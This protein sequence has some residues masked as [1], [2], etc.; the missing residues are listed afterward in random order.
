MKLLTTCIIK[1]GMKEVVLQ[2]NF[3]SQYRGGCR[4]PKKCW[5]FFHAWCAAQTKLGK[6]P[7]YAY[8][9]I[10]LACSGLGIH[11]MFDIEVPASTKAT[12]IYK[13]KQEILNRGNIVSHYRRK[14]YEL[15]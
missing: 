7:C 1:D 6:H 12:F 10:K 4:L 13:N 8:D 14:E 3:G 9:I 5:Y 11:I 15:Y 2:E